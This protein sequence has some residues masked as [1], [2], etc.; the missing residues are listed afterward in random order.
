MKKKVKEHDSVITIRDK[1][2]TKTNTKKL[3]LHIQKKKWLTKLILII[4][5]FCGKYLYLMTK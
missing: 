3:S 4:L 1:T 5:D 2:K